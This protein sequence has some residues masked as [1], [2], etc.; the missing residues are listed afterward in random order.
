MF[1]YLNYYSR[2]FKLRLWFIFSKTES[3][4]K[5]FEVPSLTSTHQVHRYMHTST[6]SSSPAMPLSQL[7]P[8]MHG[9]TTLT[10]PRILF[11]H[12]SLLNFL[13]FLSFS[14]VG[15]PMNC[16]LNCSN[17]STRFISAA[18]LISSTGQ[19]SRLSENLGFAAVDWGRNNRWK[20]S[21]YL[22]IREGQWERLYA[23]KCNGFTWKP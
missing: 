18:S 5:A 6:Q 1:A 16:F 2:V 20:N 3:I 8:Q 14:A 7:W 19:P 21:Q 13:C 22:P 11:H 12:L 15:R 10:V 17:I 23:L 4:S 9:K